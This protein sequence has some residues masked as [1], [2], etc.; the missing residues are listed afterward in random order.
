MTWNER[1]IKV[2]NEYEQ[3]YINLE[4]RDNKL[5]DLAVRMSKLLDE[6]ERDD[7]HTT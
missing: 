5:I 3:G 7:S 4:E 6:K 2:L 1:L